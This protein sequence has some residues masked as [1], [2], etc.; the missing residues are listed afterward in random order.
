MRYLE[1]GRYWLIFKSTEK[2]VWEAPIYTNN[3]TGLKNKA[4]NTWHEYFALRPKEVE[5]DDYINESGY[6]RDF[7]DQSTVNKVL[8]VG[9]MADEVDKHKSMKLRKMRLTMVVHFT[10]IE[11]RSIDRDDVVIVGALHEDDQPV[12]YEKA[13]PHVNMQ[14]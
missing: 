2:R 3:D 1:K 4:K 5:L 13:R 7:I 6:A 10:E 11:A 14:L 8:R 9:W 12:A